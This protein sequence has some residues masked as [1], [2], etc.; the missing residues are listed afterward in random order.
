MFLHALATLL[1]YALSMRLGFFKNH[2]IEVHLEDVTVRPSEGNVTAFSFV[3]QAFYYKALAINEND[4]KRSKGH[5][6]FKWCTL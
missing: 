4:Q 5:K 2:D 6:C 1:V 3:K